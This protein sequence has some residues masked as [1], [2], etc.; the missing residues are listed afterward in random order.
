MVMAAASFLKVAEECMFFLCAG[1]IRFSFCN[2]FMGGQVK[3]QDKT[4]VRFAGNFGYTPEVF[5]GP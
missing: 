4:H 1:S 5:I 2:E 3:S